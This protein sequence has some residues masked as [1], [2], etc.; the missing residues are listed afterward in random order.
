MINDIDKFLVL[1]HIEVVLQHKWRG[2]FSGMR[3]EKCAALAKGESS[4]RVYF[5]AT[6]GKGAR[7][8]P[9]TKLK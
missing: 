6:N 1:N 9:A 8:K 4:V 5:S 3:G 7:Q 2:F